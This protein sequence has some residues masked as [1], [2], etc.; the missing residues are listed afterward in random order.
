MDPRRPQPFIGAG[1]FIFGARWWMRAQ[2]IPLYILSLDYGFVFL[3]AAISP[4][5]RFNLA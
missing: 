4:R 5:V 2:I 1:E 3:G